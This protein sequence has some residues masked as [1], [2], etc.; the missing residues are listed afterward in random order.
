MARVL[1]VADMLVNASGASVGPACEYDLADC[2]SVVALGVSEERLKEIQPQTEASM[3]E[4][5]LL[6]S[7]R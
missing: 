1:H 6:F 5:A 7:F 4:V 3:N 2:E